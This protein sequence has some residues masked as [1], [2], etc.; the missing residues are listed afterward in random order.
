MVMILFQKQVVVFLNYN[1]FMVN[2]FCLF[3]LSEKFII[4]FWPF[5][6]QSEL[7]LVAMPHS[8]V[9]LPLDQKGNNKPVNADKSVGLT[10]PKQ[11]NNGHDDG[12][13]CFKDQVHVSEHCKHQLHVYVFILHHFWFRDSIS[14]LSL[15]SERLSDK[16]L[17]KAAL[18]LDCKFIKQPFGM[19]TK[20]NPEDLND[21]EFPDETL[22]RN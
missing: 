22:G 2:Y 18:Y 3:D 14:T 1:V 21:E 11:K 13:R 9:K 6:Y 17:A 12:K 16:F 5:I 10:F 20:Y 8:A 4:D 19:L 7:G 15:K